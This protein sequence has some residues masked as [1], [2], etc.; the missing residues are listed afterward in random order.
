MDYCNNEIKI[1]NLAKHILENRSTIR[2]TA[3]VFNIPKST[4][5]HDL[6]VKL[7]YI[8]YDLFKQVKKLLTQNFQIKHI[9]GGESTRIK[10]AKLKSIVDKNDEVEATSFNV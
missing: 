6:S 4:V 8:D 3:S 2:A 7:K 5:H 9:H 1:I 10:Y